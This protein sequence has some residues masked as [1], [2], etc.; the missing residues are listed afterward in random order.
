MALGHALGWINSHIILGL[1]YVLVLQPIA[2][3]MRLFNYDPLKKK[4]TDATTYRETRQTTTIDLTR[5][6]L[7]HGSFS[8]PCT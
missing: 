3:I 2:Y 6:F 1:V 5:I 4:P 7:A 8:R